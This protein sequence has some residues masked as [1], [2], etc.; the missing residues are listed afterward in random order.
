MMSMFI[1]LDMTAGAEK[2]AATD[3]HGLTLT[4]ISVCT[5]FAALVVLYFIYSLIGKIAQRSI[6]SP[7]KKDHGKRNATG[8]AADE[9]TA[10]AIAMAL[11]AEL[12]RADEAAIAMALHLHFNEYVHDTEPGII[13]IT[14]VPGAWADKTLTFRKTPRK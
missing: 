7:V 9:R 3:P 8:T 11:E 13:T 14:S 12:G 2:M 10:A 4:L 6:P 1:P 5:V